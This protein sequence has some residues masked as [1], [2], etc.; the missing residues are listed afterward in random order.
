MHFHRFAALL[1]GAWLAGSVFMDLVATQNFRSVDRLLSAPSPQATQRIQTL[2][3]HDGARVFLRY[4]VSEQ[5]R[6]YFVAWERTQ[7]PL[8]IV[9]FLVL[10]FGMTPNR[11][12]WL[13]ALV[14]IG[15]VLLMHF[16]LTPEIISL[17][18][19]MDFAPPG[20]GGHARFWTFHGLYSASELVKLA[21]GVVLAYRLLR[22]PK[23][24]EPGEV[25]RVH[26]PD[27][28]HING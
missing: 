15:I 5:N 27:H 26:E 19:A 10:L 22:K 4:L 25:D 3:G 18:R 12:S 17:G 7:I 6:T 2:G 9:L 24:S 8:G 16:F 1:I 23:I 28:S 20:T 21:L 13:L 11:F 14:M